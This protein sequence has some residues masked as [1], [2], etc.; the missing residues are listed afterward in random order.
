M[1]QCSVRSCEICENSPVKRYCKDCEQYFCKSCEIAHLKTKPCRNHIFQD[2]DTANPEVKTPICKQHGEKFT[3]YCNTC[4]S[5]TCNI[6]LPTTHNKHDFC[7]IDAAASKARSVLD[8]DVL[9]AEDSI[10]R[11]KDKTNSSRLALTNFEYE[12]EKVK[13]DIVE[14]VVFVVNAI[15]DTKDD[16]L[17]SINEHTF[18][19]SQKLKQ[20]ILDSEK[21]T[22]NCQEVLNKVKNSI[23]GENNVMLLDSF[24]DMTKTLK[25]VSRVS[26]ETTIPQ[27]IQ[28]YPVLT[29]PESEKL[30]GNINITKPNIIIKEADIVRFIKPNTTIKRGDRV[31]LKN[32]THRL[33]S[34]ESIGKVLFI[35]RNNVLVKFPEISSWSGCLSEIELA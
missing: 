14:R 9:A 12:A 28:F 16:Y 29:R 6:C 30:I 5:L 19:E 20:E 4:T 7:L 26:P 21:A 17:K 34:Q 35:A 10:G 25:T 3:Y 23:A 22:E 2:A 18:K 27:R 15:N 24:S 1:A 11:T 31:R 32:P 33:I 13:R 8:K